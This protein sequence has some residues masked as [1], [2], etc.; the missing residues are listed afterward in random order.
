MKRLNIYLRDLGKCI[1]RQNNDGQS[2]K[3]HDE[4]RKKRSG[5]KVWKVING[6]S[7]IEDRIVFYE[8]FKNKKKKLNN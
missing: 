2:R 3:F 6:K 8:K 4:P 7:M 1:R 5:K